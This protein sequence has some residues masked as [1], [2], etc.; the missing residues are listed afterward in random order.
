MI[1]SQD[2]FFLETNV[3]LDPRA[4][5]FHEFPQSSL[6]FV[7]FKSNVLGCIGGSTE[8]L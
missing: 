6:L 3:D 2:Q 1:I 5:P 7:S 8:N 4:F